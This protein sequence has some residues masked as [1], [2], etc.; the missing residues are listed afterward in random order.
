[1]LMLLLRGARIHCRTVSAQRPAQPLWRVLRECQHLPF[2]DSEAI[3]GSSGR[4]MMKMSSSLMPSTLYCLW[5]LLSP[6]WRGGP[7]FCL[8]RVSLFGVV[9]DVA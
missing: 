3:E 8:K 6:L 5:T 7:L 2:K 9:Q 1:M 4:D